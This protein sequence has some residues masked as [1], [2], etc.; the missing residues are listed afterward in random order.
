LVPSILILHFCND[1]LFIGATVFDTYLQKLVSYI[2]FF[3]LSKEFEA[4]SPGMFAAVR[5]M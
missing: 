3:T 2:K 4:I 5:L 1:G